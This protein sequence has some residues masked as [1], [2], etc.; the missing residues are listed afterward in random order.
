MLLHGYELEMDDMDA[1]VPCGKL[2]GVCLTA[3]QR[4][5]DYQYQNYGNIGNVVLRHTQD[6]GTL[7]HLITF[8]HQIFD[9]T[10][11]YIVQNMYMYICSE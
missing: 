1:T 9:H 6:A 2:C 7:N 8:I 11:K 3:H 10:N 4:Y 5:S